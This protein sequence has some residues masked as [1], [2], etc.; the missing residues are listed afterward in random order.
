M[1]TIIIGCGKVGQKLAEKLSQE[2]NQNITV[3]DLKY[4]LVQNIINQHD[5]MGV[6]GNGASVETLIEAGVE[7]ADILI[8][9][10]G[11]DEVN[12]L[13]CLV[14]KKAGGCQTISRVR[15]P[16][17]TESVRLLKADLG[18]EMIINPEYTAAS[19]IARVLRF[20]SAVQIDT[21]AKGRV[22]I[23]KFRL[24]KESVLDNM[25]VVQ[26]S[27][28]ISSDILIC[29]VE[30]EDKAY[31]PSGD[32]VLKSGDLVSIVAPVGTA[33]KFF[34]KINIKTNRVKDAIIVGGGGISYYLA[35]RLLATGIKV[36]I[37]EIDEERCNELCELIPEAEIINAD[38]TDNKILLQEGLEY[39][40][41]FIALTNIDEENILLSL[42]AKS[43]SD[44][45]LV[46]KIN[47]IA[48]DEVIS[49]LELD[50]TIYPKNIT[51]EY[52]VRFVRAK[53]NSMGNNIETMHNILDGKA[54]ALEFI[55]A[56]NSPVA[57]IPLEQLKLKENIL[58]ACIINNGKI[59]IPRG[60]DAMYPG[61]NV[62]VVTTN[63]GFNDITDILE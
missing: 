54:E 11:S 19:E 9:V 40:D 22:E 20:P 26:M 23:L 50:T 49:N 15:T 44:G 3:V 31:I 51:A 52:I 29:G 42:F 33:G 21:F 58:I 45:K 34:K 14:A 57:G 46:T 16:E 12:L 18:L 28:K 62:I 48:Y 47:R 6:V 36:K 25:S 63:T 5:A 30:R 59:K 17:Y 38:G 4:N 41:S 60:R 32:F 2:E 10:T 37:I 7:S 27:Q 61:D 55:I 8:A 1:N 24:P 39:A 53:H 56:K 13:T 35:K 43:K